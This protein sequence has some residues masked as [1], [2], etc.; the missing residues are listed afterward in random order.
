MKDIRLFPLSTVAE[1]GSRGF[2]AELDGSML[3]GFVVRKA[4]LLRAYRNHCP[5]TGAPLEWQPDQ[6]LDIGDSFIQ[7][8]LH[9]ALFDVDEGRCLRGPCVGEHLQPLQVRV[10]D[11]DVWLQVPPASVEPS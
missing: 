8:A 7:C 10:H 4:G 1:P 3:S 6:F 5:H 9:G 2:E 11:G